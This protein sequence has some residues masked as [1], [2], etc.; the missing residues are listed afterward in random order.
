MVQG[1]AGDWWYRGE[2]VTGVCG[3]ERPG[4]HLPLNR[5]TPFHQAI[6][7]EKGA[8]RKSA[9]PLVELRGHRVDCF[10]DYVCQFVGC[11][12]ITYTILIC[13]L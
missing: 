1:R 2:L 9:N 4:V 8:G 11:F 10:V 5:R 6:E 12:L 7:L 3:Q 13:V